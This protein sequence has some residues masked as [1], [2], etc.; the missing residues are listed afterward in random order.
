MRLTVVGD[1]HAKPNNLD[2]ITQLFDHIEELGN[3]CIILGDLLDTK[4][5]VRGR[6]LNH[7]FHR[8]EKSSLNFIVLTSTLR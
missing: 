7:Y 3:T 2:K 4:E 5:L 1:P 8:F 6:C